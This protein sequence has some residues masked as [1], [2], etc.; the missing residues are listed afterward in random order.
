MGGQVALAVSNMNSFE[1]IAALNIRVKRTGE[2]YRT[3]L[4]IDNALI[5]QLT[6][7]TLLRYVL[8]ILRRVVPLNG[9]PIA[10][11]H[12]ANETYRPYSRSSSIYSA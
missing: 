6:R 4:E 10:I 1:E 5:I 7:E 8:E 11:Y 9:A 3:L 12:P 2:R